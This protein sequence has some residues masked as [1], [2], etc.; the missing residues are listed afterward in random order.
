[1]FHP[2]FF[3][4]VVDG[5]LI[6]SR[7][8][9]FKQYLANLKGE[10]QLTITRRK[11]I[12][13]SAEN[14]YYWGVIVPMV[15]EEMGLIPDEAH[16]YLKSLFLKIGYESKGKRYELARSTAILSTEE[17]EAY[18]EK[19]RQWASA[20]LNVYIPLPNEI[21]WEGHELMVKH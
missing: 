5:K 17:F 20:E 3:G 10:V 4:T 21:T 18:A 19:C 14:A 16:D 15:A 9:E 6:L 12:R 11:K 8:S 1:M 13:S 2:I 7:S